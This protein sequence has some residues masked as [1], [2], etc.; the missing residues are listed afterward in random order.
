MSSK[1]C[2]RNGLSEV[3]ITMFTLN[4]ITWN[5]TL[6]LLKKTGWSLFSPDPQVFLLEIKLSFELSGQGLAAFQGPPG[7]MVASTFGLF[8]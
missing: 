2:C 8:L 6:E 4:T 3:E 7:E 1:S 5:L